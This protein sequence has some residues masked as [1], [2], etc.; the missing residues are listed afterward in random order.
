MFIEDLKG[1]RGEYFGLWGIWPPGDIRKQKQ[2]TSSESYDI[3]NSRPHIF[4]SP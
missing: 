3:I 4:T 1:R 2:L